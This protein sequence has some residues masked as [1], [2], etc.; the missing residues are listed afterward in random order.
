M[1]SENSTRLV[2]CGAGLLVDGCKRIWMCA[3]R[4]ARGGCGSSMARGS[5]PKSSGNGT[6]TSL[7]KRWCCAACD[8]CWGS[9]DCRCGSRHKISIRSVSHVLGRGHLEREFHKEFI[10]NCM[11][12]CVVSWSL[13]IKSG[14]RLRSGQSWKCRLERQCATGTFSWPT[15]GRPT[16]RVAWIG[17]NFSCISRHNCCKTSTPGH[18]SLGSSPS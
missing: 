16:R 10:P 13:F 7:P 11:E 17:R 18:F 2:A 5:S 12:P 6:S 1:S 9:G 8:P 3:R 15:I 14:R 4:A